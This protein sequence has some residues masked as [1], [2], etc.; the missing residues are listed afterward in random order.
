MK[1]NELISAKKT[2]YH[3]KIVTDNSE[4]SKN[5]FKPVGKMLNNKNKNNTVLLEVSSDKELAD[6]FSTFFKSKISKINASFQER[7]EQHSDIY[8]S[9]EPMCMSNF[10]AFR[11]VTPDEITKIHTLDSL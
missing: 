9:Q 2:A 11:P 1:Y 10:P 4:N 6:S 5:L 8:L 3:N 7:N